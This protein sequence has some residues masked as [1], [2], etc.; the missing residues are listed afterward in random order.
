MQCPQCGFENREDARFCKRCGHVLQGA[1]PPVIL[2]CPVCGAALK[3]GARFCARC[4]HECTPRPG[5]ASPQEHQPV[6]PAAPVPV[7]ADR[8]AIRP[9]VKLVGSGLSKPANAKRAERS[10]V[11]W[12]LALVAL[13]LMFCLSCCGVLALGL[14]P[15]LNDTPPAAILG[16]PNG[17]DITILVREAYLNENLVAILPEKGLKDASLDVQPNNLLMTTANFDLV[18]VSLELKIMARLSVVD[19]EIVVSI[20]DIVAGGS[21]LMQ[22]LNMDEVTLGKNFTRA[23]REQLENELGEGSRLL[24]ITTDEEHIILKARL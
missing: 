12:W 2:T 23:L 22:F 13:G 14:L 5:S 9:P 19:G 17:H 21:D 11:G 15:G 18:F 24:D 20:E 10:I 6:Q 3:P 4:G 8:D 16:D 1:S 7:S